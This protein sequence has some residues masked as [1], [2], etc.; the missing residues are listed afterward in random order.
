MRVLGGIFLPDSRLIF[1][2]LD[3]KLVMIPRVL[4]VVPSL[5]LKRTKSP[6]LRG[7][8]FPSWYIQALRIDVQSML[9]LAFVALLF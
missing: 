4:S 9:F 2:F 7:I 6:I 5:G 3:V 8:P 1:A